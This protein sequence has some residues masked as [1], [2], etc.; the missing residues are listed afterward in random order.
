[1]EGIYTIPGMESVQDCSPV[2]G[3]LYSTS[4]SVGEECGR[5]GANGVP[6]GMGLNKWNKVQSDESIPEHIARI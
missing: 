2:S 3:L 6:R 5:I 1:M 4:S